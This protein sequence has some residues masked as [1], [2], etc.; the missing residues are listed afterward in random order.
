MTP[1]AFKHL[2]RIFLLG[3][4]MALGA[5][6]G[7]AKETVTVQ[8]P[9]THQ[10]QFAGFYAAEAK[11]FFREEGLTVELRE[12]TQDIKPIE[13]VTEG[14]ADYGIYPSAILLARLNGRPI[15][16][17]AAIFQYSPFLLAVKSDS[18]ITTP[19]DLLNKR[20]ALG[21]DTS[22][23]DIQ[24]MLL[25]EGLNPTQYQLVPSKW[26]E[27]EVMAGQADAMS[28]FATDAPYDFAQKGVALRYLRPTDYGIDFYGDCLFTSETEA[29]DRARRVVAM[30]RAVLRGWEYAVEHPEEII[31]WMQA[32][33]KLPA[34][35]TAERLRFE[36]KATAKHINAGLVRVG[37]MNAGRWEVIGDMYARLGHAPDTGRLEGFIFD[38]TGAHHPW[39]RWFRWGVAGV[40]GV[41]GLL[42]LWN[43]RLRTEVERRTA[44]L[45]SANEREHE[46]F[47]KAP[48]P[49]VT[50]DYGAVADELELRRAGGLTDLAAQLRQEPDLARLL[51]ALVRLTQCNQA[52]FALIGCDTVEQANRMRLE[53]GA[54]AFESFKEE[55]QVIWERRPGF[56]TE[57]AY[58]RP[59]G[60]RIDTLLHWSA[61]MTPA[62]PDYRR[63]N[64]AFTVLTDVREAEAARREVEE[65]YH[66]LFEQ[67][68]T[69]IVTEDYRPLVARLEELRAGGVRDIRAHLDQNPRE[70]P[71]LLECTRITEVN[72]A[73]LTHSGAANPDEHE[74]MVAANAMHTEQSLAM[75]REQVAAVWEGRRS[76]TLEKTFRTAQG[77]PLHTL[78][79]WSVAERD[80][81]PD[82]SRV[83]MIFS[84]ITESKRAEAALRESEE[85]HRRLF[86]ENPNPLYIYDRETLRFLE[87]NHAAVERYG[88]TRE[89]FLARTIL[90]IRPADEQERLRR[91]VTAPLTGPVPP[92]AG[93]W[94]HVRKDGAVRRVEVFTRNITQQ[95]RPAV[96]VLPIDLTDQINAEAELRQSEERYRL[97]FE[98]SPLAI[99][100][101]D[102]TELKPWFEE[103]R[104]AGV[105]DLAA[106][107]EAHPHLREEVLRRAPLVNLND[108]TV[109]LIGGQTKQE[110]FGKL[111]EIFTES[112]VRVRC[113]NAARIW[114]GVTT[115]QGE[116]E[117]RRLD[118]QLRTLEFYWRMQ[119][120]DGRPTFRRT[121]TVLVDITER[122]RTEAALRESE[123][124]YREVFEN[125]IDGIYRS[126]PEG[127][128]IAVNPALA[129]ML[130]F[131]S[132]EE[133][134]A[135]DT[136]AGG[137]PLYVK[138]GRREE[139][140]ALHKGGR[141]VTGFESEVRRRDGERIWISENVRAITDASGRVRYYE[142]FVSDITP[143]RRLEA[144]LTRASKLEAVGILAGGIA[145]DFNNILTVVLGNITLAE[146][147]TEAQASVAALLRDAKRATLRARD[148]TQQLLTFAKGGDPV[149]AAIELP[150]LLRESVEFALHGAKA[151]AEYAISSDLWAV[152]ADKG[153][154]G[155]V[156]QNLVINAVQAMPQGLVVTV[157]AE[158]RPLQDRNSLPLAPGNYVRLSVEDTGV[159]IPAEHLAKIFDPYFT[160]K[161]TGSGLGL[162]TV[163]SIVKKHQGHIEV[164]SQLGVGTRFHIWLPAAEAQPA[165]APLRR[166]DGEI[167]GARILFMD[168]EEGIRA[169]AALFIGRFGAE[170]ELAED[171]AQAVEKFLQA[172]A[173]GRP[174][175]AV[176]MDLTVPGGMG[177][178]EAMQRLLD[179][180]P[181]VKV[182]VSS[183]Y[184]RDPVMA[185]HKAH[186]FKGILPKPYGP[187]QM[188]AALHSVLLGRNSAAPFS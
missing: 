178:R 22:R 59:D 14:R 104:A 151:R 12:A 18:S 25:A 23:I 52:A 116:I 177:G 43:W 17:V 124:R 155:Q 123:A 46:L 135:H 34:R 83:T 80:G 35:V 100:E 96:L 165:T 75:F 51:G 58:V 187:D 7:R 160:T 54:E 174:F 33:L 81:R 132:P 148:L 138:P 153:Q 188:R 95:G 29:T 168:D 140:R 11:G 49:M 170:V 118:G 161:Q 179:L 142:G 88:Y 103:L 105:E 66:R 53:R 87:V 20:L 159:G 107:F 16:A 50:L 99:V 73:A 30:R 102:Y 167:A 157:R 97:L 125:A 131:A 158:N 182:V 91:M 70:L 26:D 2:P 32:N 119:T 136:N 143:R 115:N 8:L 106:H 98:Q 31:N 113:E 47:D 114:R 181:G 76:L 144:E 89:E 28:V 186:G 55:L 149:R 72:P 150:E 126:S 154:I 175:D 4:A 110:L 93:Q 147:D 63:V 44:E 166:L 137:A 6:A 86:D 128:F 3:G 65:K 84:D 134:I 156:V 112:A 85:R 13:E 74:R 27:D 111:R 101:F 67:A 9:F 92:H 145:H 141:F 21:R 183:G 109:L 38:E 127:K 169:M 121:Q 41:V 48:L 68:T 173:G 42:L 129:R 62:G 1:A 180:D 152:N 71:A 163:Y 56:R 108:Q 64:A 60:R 130:G 40:A 79:N 39:W 171:G 120:Q 10:F 37:H 57:R 185:N 184:S 19:A 164:E 162:A 172:R 45:R 77:R 24:A 94:R 61:P 69:P 176:I 82:Y 122:K 36:A 117:V 133:L 139:F 5:L 90:D 146:Q 78:M 15:V